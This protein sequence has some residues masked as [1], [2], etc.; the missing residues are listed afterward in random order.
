MA[1][2]QQDLTNIE[3][4]IASGALEVRYADRTVVYRSMKDLEIARAAIRQELFAQS[5][6]VPIRQT[7]VWTDKGWGC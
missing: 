7:R 3:T 2:T 1:W 4:A 5:G 6:S